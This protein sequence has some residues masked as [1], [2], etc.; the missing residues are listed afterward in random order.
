MSGF[1]N[2][3]SRD[4]FGPPFVDTRPIRNPATQVGQK[5]LELIAF[6]TTGLGLV[7][8]RAF[9]IFDATAGGA[10]PPIVANAEAWNTKKS[11][12]APY[13]P[14]VI[15]RSAL[16]IYTVTYQATYPDEAGNAKAISIL[17]AYGAPLGSSNV[18]HVAATVSAGVITA[19]LR[20]SDLAT[21]AWSSV[22]GKVIVWML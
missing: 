5:L 12:A 13:L 4:D 21:G 18:R 11:S 9:V 17:D 16:G 19:K 20:E 3:P 22:D 1:P 2:R 8:A 14:P 15:A 10:N 7:A 6:Q